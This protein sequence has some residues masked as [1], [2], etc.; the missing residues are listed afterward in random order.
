LLRVL[1]IAALVAAMIP[2]CAEQQA[3]AQRDIAEIMM[4][5]YHLEAEQEQFTIYYRFS[6][7]EG[8]GEGGTENLDARI[9][10][11]GIDK[12]QT[13]LVINIDNIQS[14]GLLSLRFPEELVSADANNF[15]LLVD[16]KERGY[17]LSR[18]GNIVG[19]ILILP[20]NSTTV[21]I[22]GT[23]VIPEFG[24]FVIV[25]LTV[26]LASIA[27]LGRLLPPRIGQINN[28]F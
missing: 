17:E 12:E 13:S 24:P 3:Q 10:S 27:I 9:L 7:L 1:P 2:V 21:E 23:R 14:T 5:K 15:T 6:I 19:M 28:N 8:A 26:S 18:Q 22:V 25:M 20:E 16:G 11:M 4:Q